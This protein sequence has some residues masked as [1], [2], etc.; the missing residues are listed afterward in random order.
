MASQLH[1]NGKVF[2]GRGEDDFVTAFR[3]T[4]DV[5]SWVGDRADVAGERAVD[6]QGRTVV[7][8]FLDVHTPTRR[9]WRRWSTP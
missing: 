2:T 6:L 9:S 5:F 8:G 4:D 3:I 1:I 7:P